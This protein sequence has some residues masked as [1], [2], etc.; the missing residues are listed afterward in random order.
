MSPQNQILSRSVPL[1]ILRWETSACG[2]KFIRAFHF[3][4]KTHSL[5]IFHSP[6]Y[7]FHGQEVR[8]STS[9]N[10][11]LDATWTRQNARLNG[12]SLLFDKWFPTRIPPDRRSVG[13]NSTGLL[14]VFSW[15]LTF[16]ETLFFFSFFFLT[17]YDSN[18]V[19]LSFSTHYTA[20]YKII[21]ANYLNRLHD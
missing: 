6:F 3:V 10:F 2:L 5:F 21:Y 15:W 13:G 17:K 18:L 7:L 8:Q 12:L 20:N 9:Q 11:V 16:L 14:C 1:S 4:E 19:E